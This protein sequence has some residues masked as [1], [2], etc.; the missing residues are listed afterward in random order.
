MS[1]IE[2]FRNI[3]HCSVYNHKH[4]KALVIELLMTFYDLPFMKCICDIIHVVF[5]YNTNTCQH[6]EMVG[7]PKFSFCKNAFLCRTISWPALS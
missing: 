3:T 6:L 1:V 4:V 2:L 5:Y 7:I